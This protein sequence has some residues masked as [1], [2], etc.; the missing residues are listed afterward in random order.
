M[1]KAIYQGSEDEGL[2]LLSRAKDVRLA[3]V[4]ETGMPILR[5]V[6][7]VVVDGALAFHGAP[8]GE[9]ME[10]I[11]RPV[12]A[13]ADETVVSIPS[14]F[15]DPERACPATTYYVSAQVEGVLELVGDMERKARVLSALMQKYQP[16]G[17]HVPLSADHPL[18][19]KAIAGLLVAEIAQGRIACKTKL[20]QNRQPADR[21]RVIEQLWKRGARG[22]ALAVAML[23]ARFPELGTPSFLRPSEELHAAGVRFQCAMEDDEIDEAVRLL[24]GMYWVTTFS[25]AE[26]RAAIAASSA[27][28]GGRD[29]RGRLMAFA[30]AVADTRCAWIYDVV[31]AE[32]HRGTRVGSAMMQVLLDHPSVRN[33]RHVRLTT[34]DAMSFY[35]RLGFC[36]LAE[37][38][39]AQRSEP[40]A[41]GVGKEEAPRHPW[42]SVDMIR[43]RAVVASEGSGEAQTRRAVAKQRS[44][45]RL[46]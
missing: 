11:G 34:R 35:R 42:P 28:V 24:E 39:G 15:L 10:G 32:E 33:V 16:E 12:I 30:R 36:E 21:V 37:A 46:P 44:D 9:K 6:N 8:A 20:G 7:A 25:R 23:L 3:M 4:S 2:A 18:Y 27:V 1:R 29:A 31:V 41:R 22:D 13:S 5:T 26:L 45:S 14:Y 40:S 17:G 19:K 38:R 43:S